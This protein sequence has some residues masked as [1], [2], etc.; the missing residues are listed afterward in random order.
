MQNFF[1]THLFRLVCPFTLT[2]NGSKFKGQSRMDMNEAKG[3]RLL[4]MCSSVSSFR[5]TEPEVLA[6]VALM[7]M[8][9][10]MRLGCTY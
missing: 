4:K 6:S 8:C 5:F 10:Q 1:L 3:A 7:R 2:T 9:V